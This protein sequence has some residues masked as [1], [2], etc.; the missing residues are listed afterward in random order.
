MIPLCVS[1]TIKELCFRNHFFLDRSVDL[2]PK[3]ACKGTDNFLRCKGGVRF[4]FE[5]AESRLE[6]GEYRVEMTSLLSLFY[7][8]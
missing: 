6:I 8:L 1:P 3:I 7:N 2:Y 4:L 5:I